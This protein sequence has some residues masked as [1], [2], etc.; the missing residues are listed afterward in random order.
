[1][2]L[3]CLDTTAEE[4]QELGLAQNQRGVVIV[5]VENGSQAEASG[6]QRGDVLLSVNNTKVD[7]TAEYLAAARAIKKGELVRLYLKRETATIFLAF[8]K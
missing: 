5:N 3:T 4:A 2:G 8:T 1:L 6:V 7:T